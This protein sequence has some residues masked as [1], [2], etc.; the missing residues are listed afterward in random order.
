MSRK[1][2]AKI[3]SSSVPLDLSEILLGEV[4]CSVGFMC[5][6]DHD[7]LQHSYSVENGLRR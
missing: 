3:L 1:I 7:L 6:R 4:L 2:K 5:N